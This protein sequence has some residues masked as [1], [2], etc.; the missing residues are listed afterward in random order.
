MRIRSVAVQFLT[1]H[2]NW[3]AIH[4]SPITTSYPPAT[5]HTSTTQ[6]RMIRAVNE[7]SRS[8]TMP[9]KGL[10]S[11]YWSLKGLSQL[12]ILV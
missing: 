5:I 7:T 4:W 3:G 11:A 10:K 1:H 12:R 8:F 6:A 9:G 2:E